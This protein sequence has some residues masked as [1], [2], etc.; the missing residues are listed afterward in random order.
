VFICSGR[1]GFPIASRREIPS[2]RDL[3]TIPLDAVWRFSIAGNQRRNS[4]RYGAPSRDTD[5]IVDDA[6]NVF[7]IADGYMTSFDTDRL[8][9]LQK[10]GC[11]SKTGADDPRW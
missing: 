8:A 4:G 9:G 1:F 3:H 11:R 5:E 10:V 6:I 7:G 2:S